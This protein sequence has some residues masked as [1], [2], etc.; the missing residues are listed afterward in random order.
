[1]GEIEREDLADFDFLDSKGISGAETMGTE[2][3][4]GVGSSFDGPATKAAAVLGL[5]GSLDGVGARTGGVIGGGEACRIGRGTG[6]NGASR[7][8][9]FGE[10]GLKPGFGAED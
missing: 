7:F 10:E 6:D 5:R 9:F 1:M 3:G 8:I 2:R 4:R